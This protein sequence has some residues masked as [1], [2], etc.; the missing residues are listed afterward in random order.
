M[1]KG[2]PYVIER[3]GDEWVLLADSEKKTD[4]VRELDGYRGEVSSR[5]AGKRAEEEEVRPVVSYGSLLVVALGLVLMSVFQAESGPEWREK[6]I[7]VSGLIVRGGEW[8]RLVTAL[9]LHGDVPHVLAN[10]AGGLLFAGCLIQRFGQGVTWLLILI[11]GALGNLCNAWI[12]G[13][14]EHRSLGASTGVFG[15]L[16]LLTG[17]VLVEVLLHKSG[18]SWWRWTVPLGGGL[19]L[20]AFLGTGGQGAHNVDVLAHFWGFLAGL[21]LGAVF[22]TMRPVRSVK[23]AAQTLCGLL[24]ASVVLLSW[25]WAFSV[26]KSG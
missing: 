8:W 4:A 9:T 7:L 2:I 18:V 12:Y 16:G 13:N 22:G 21:V 20:L 15:A 6:G 19:A 24:A 26:G 17:D 3:S 14:V 1:A 25:Y 10:M 11:S 5:R 23:P